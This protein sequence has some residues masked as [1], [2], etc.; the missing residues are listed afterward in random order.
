MAK[1]QS[2][3]NTDT[4]E[5]TSLVKYG[6]WSMDQVDEDAKEMAS[7]SGDFLKLETGKNRI[8]FLPPKMGWK[9]P[10]VIQHQHFIKMPGLERAI[11]FSCPKMHEGKRCLACEKA[12]QMENAGNARD[13]KFAKELKPKKRMMANVIAEPDDSEAAIKILGFGVQIFNQLKAIR[14][15]GEAGGNFMDPVNGFVININ[16]VGQKLDTEYTCIPVRQQ[17]PLA[18]MDWIEQQGDLRKLIR[19][20]TVDQ[21]KRL[22]DGEDAKD[23]WAEPKGGD[24]DEP[25][26]RSSKPAS[27]KKDVIDVKPG[28]RTAEDDMFDDEVELD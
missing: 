2:T 21:Q 17:T 7:G 4:K 19:I 28:K 12:T 26:P 13:G 20:P 5:E 23:V 27:S 15:D 24:E 10:F 3:K 9:T 18:N 14:E 6:E 22:F 8:R 11:I 1:P 25:A 16:R